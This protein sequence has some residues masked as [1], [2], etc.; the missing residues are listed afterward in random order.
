MS[1]VIFA[2]VERTESF[3]EQLRPVKRKL[4]K[5]NKKR[6]CRTTYRNLG[7][8]NRAEKKSRIAKENPNVQSYIC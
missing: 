7:A 4:T 8:G 3:R 1:V 6:K 2:F 5:K